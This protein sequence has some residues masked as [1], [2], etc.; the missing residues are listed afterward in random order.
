MTALSPRER[1]GGYLSR[2]LPWTASAA[3][4]LATAAALRMMGRPWWCACAKPFLWAGDAWSS[5]NSQHLF[6][7]YSFTHLLHGIA[8]CGL[9]AWVRPRL[10]VSNALPTVIA[11]EGIWEIVENSA[12]VIDRYRTATISLNYSGD[13]IANSLG[14]ILACGMGFLFARRLGLVWSAAVWLVI[15]IVLVVWIRDNLFLSTLMLVFPLDAIKAW[16]MGG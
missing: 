14:D 7:P 10:A 1:S 5:H 16:Q 8:F 9:L 11:A 13:T 2:C 6:D 15:E 12:F 3:I 4:A